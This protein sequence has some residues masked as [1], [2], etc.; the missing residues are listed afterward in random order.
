MRFIRLAKIYQQCDIWRPTTSANGPQT[1]YCFVRNNYSIFDN[2][3]SDVEALDL[4]QHICLPEVF[5]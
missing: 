4:G 2:P 5:C 1:R 3:T